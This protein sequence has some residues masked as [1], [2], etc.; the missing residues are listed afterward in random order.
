MAPSVAVGL[1]RLRSNFLATNS[2]PPGAAREGVLD[3][4]TGV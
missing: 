4:C 2:A 1:G 3:A